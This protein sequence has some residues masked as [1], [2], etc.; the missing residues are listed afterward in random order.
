MT[1]MHHQERILETN[2]FVEN[3]KFKS[4]LN[5]VQ[6]LTKNTNIELDIPITTFNLTN[7]LKIVLQATDTFANLNGSNVFTISKGSLSKIDLSQWFSDT[8][9]LPS[10]VLD[11]VI[12]KL[13]DI[14]LLQNIMDGQLSLSYSIDD[15]GF[16]TVSLSINIFKVKLGNTEWDTEVNLEIDLKIK[17]SNLPVVKQGI[18][19]VDFAFGHTSEIFFA[20]AITAVLIATPAVIEGIATDA[21]V[22]TAIIGLCSLI[23]KAFGM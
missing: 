23:Q 14:S 15:D 22:N 18:E 20:L 5:V 3:P 17:P 7:S 9:N 16:Y 1:K 13:M 6:S 21:I 11:V 10:P 8:F 4:A 2:R 12:G 19:A